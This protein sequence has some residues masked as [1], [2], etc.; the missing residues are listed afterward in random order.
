[1]H[2]GDGCGVTLAD[3]MAETFALEGRIS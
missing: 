2:A 1:M 3:G